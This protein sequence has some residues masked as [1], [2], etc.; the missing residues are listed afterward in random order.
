MSVD[1][2]DPSMKQMVRRCCTCT[3]QFGELTLLAPY[4]K[5]LEEFRQEHPKKNITEFFDKY[6]ISRMCCRLHLMTP[7]HIRLESVESPFYAESSASLIA[8]N[9]TQDLSHLD[10]IP[11]QELDWY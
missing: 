7:Y 2:K 5:L 1:S 11:N 10:V 8:T 4:H 6:H 3:N 9:F